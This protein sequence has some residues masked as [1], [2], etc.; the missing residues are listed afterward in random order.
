MSTVGVGVSGT[1]P[2]GQRY[3]QHQLCEL[4]TAVRRQ[5]DRH[6][7]RQTDRQR[8]G[9]VN[10]FTTHSTQTGRQQCRRTVVCARSGISRHCVLFTRA[11]LHK[12]DIPSACPSRLTKR[13]CIKT[14]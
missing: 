14:A 6:T 12:R 3:R 4:C 7:Q 2:D 10:L 11:I 13:Y 1:Y 5:T 9:H 8:D